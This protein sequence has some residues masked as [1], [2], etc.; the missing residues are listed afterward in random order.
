MIKVL[1]NS[2]FILA[3]LHPAEEQ[4]HLLSNMILVALVDTDDLEDA[5]RLT[6]HTGIDWWDQP[7][8]I[9]L[10]KSRSTSVG[11]VLIDA[12]GQAHRVEAMGFSPFSWELPQEP[13]YFVEAMTARWAALI[14]RG[15]GD[16]AR[17]NMTLADMESCIT[18]AR[19]KAER[20]E[21]IVEMEILQEMARIYQVQAGMRP[22]AN[23]EAEALAVGRLA[24]QEEE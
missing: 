3:H 8:V 12:E 16:P 22:L 17:R 7:N 20:E 23:A 1:H 10:V 13:T 21:P 9:A 5:Y 18:Y 15:H 19:Q 4:F 11:D 14:R 6:N 2:D 24:H